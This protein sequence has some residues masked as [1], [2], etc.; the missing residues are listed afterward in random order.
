M[1]KRSF[2]RT[3]TNQSAPKASH[4]ATTAAPAL[5]SLLPYTG[6]WTSRH[7]LHLLNR[8]G[9]GPTREEILQ[10]TE[11]GL[12]WAIDKLFEAQP[13]PDPPIHFRY[14]DDPEAPLGETWVNSNPTAGVNGL[15]NARRLSLQLWMTGNMHSS[16]L[17][18][19]EKMVLFWHEHFPVAGLNLGIFGYK[20]NQIIRTHALGNF[21][22]LLEEMTI[23]DAMLLYLN[24]NENTA[25]APNENFAR[26]LLELFTLGRGP[27]AGPGDY[28]TY[29]E[30]D[31]EVLARALTGWR[32]ARRDDALAGSR[33]TN[34]R[35]DREDKVLSERF[36]SAVITNNGEDEYKDVIDIILKKPEVG[37]HLARQLHIWFVSANIDDE[38]EQDVIRPL[39]DMIRAADYNIEPALRT[40]LVSEYFNS[41]AHSGCIVSSPID[42]IMK[43]IKPLKY[44]VRNNDTARYNFWNR[45]KSFAAGL[46]MNLMELPEVAGWKAYYQ[47]PQ[48]SRFWINAFSLNKR[49]EFIIA[50][51]SST[52]DAGVPEVDLID[53]I[54]ELGD[55]ALDPYK[56][57][58]AITEVLF[59]F[60]ISTNQQEFLKEV[61]I[62]GLP[63]YAWTNQYNEY[64]AD[65]NNED[66]ELAIRN[67][68]T[69]LFVNILKMPEFHLI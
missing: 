61:L 5:A 48:Y 65:P 54:T 58:N 53:F 13:E 35:H 24:G 16:S 11:E 1:D 62:P 46:E 9:F 38:V 57:I 3:I 49:E 69:R 33:F 30:Q 37:Y 40:L 52:N 41:G 28:T 8:T 17:N 32:T 12:I 50:V 43:V 56:M 20:Y 18:I 34:G 22:T 39:G 4:T 14:E 2:L 68:L 42:F 15:T 31:I 63:D 25:E 51:L 59:P 6:P 55:D 10:V 26:E 29:T 60:E 21:R 64:I 19:K 47:V 44:R 36:E 66:L 45:I 67:R 27:L 7:A 23:S